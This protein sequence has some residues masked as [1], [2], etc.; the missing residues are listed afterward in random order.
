MGSESIEIQQEIEFEEVG[1]IMT[2]KHIKPNRSRTPST[3]NSYLTVGERV[4][5]FM[6][7]EPGKDFTRAEIQRGIHVKDINLDVYL[8][9][10]VAKGRIRRPIKGIYRFLVAQQVPLPEP[11]EE[12][13]FHNLHL[14]LWGGGWGSPNNLNVVERA[15]THLTTPLLDAPNPQQALPGQDLIEAALPDYSTWETFIEGQ[16][17]AIKV[18]RG[19]RPQIAF[20]ASRNPLTIDLLERLL[21]AVSSRYGFDFENDRWAVT[22]MEF[23]RD[24]PTLKLEGMSCLTIN[25]MMGTLYRFYNKPRLGL[26]MEATLAAPITTTGVVALRDCLAYT[27]GEGRK[28]EMSMLRSEI[29]AMRAEITDARKE[30][31]YLSKAARRLLDELQGTSFN[32][33]ID[34]TIQKSLKKHL[35][36]GDSDGKY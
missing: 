13:K 12:V 22:Q 15:N 3:S 35:G 19:P 18:Q 14:T 1:F 9:R 32:E 25:D 4:L 28:G 26:R 10:L 17:W 21:D 5:Q 36:K 7:K 16:A 6:A 24:F 29:H 27:K 34:A 30:N 11:E 31:Q 8:G 20:L 2:T 33:I 23:N